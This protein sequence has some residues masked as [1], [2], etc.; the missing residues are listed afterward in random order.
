M[1]IGTKDIIIRKLCILTF[2]I[3]LLHPVCNAPHGPYV[4][5]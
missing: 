3:K 5:Y 2:K 1:L 4:L